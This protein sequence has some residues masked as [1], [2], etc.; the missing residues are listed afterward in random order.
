MKGLK[1]KPLILLFTLMW[2]MSFANTVAAQ[3]PS[4]TLLVEN[5]NLRQGEEQTV[6]LSV[7]NIPQV[8]GADIELT[9]DPQVLEVVD[10]DASKDGIQLQSGDFINPEQE[11]GFFLQNQVDN[12]NGVIDYALTLLN[13]A[14]AVEGDGVLANITLRA[15]SDGESQLR[16]K[17]GE[18]G[19]R[20]GEVI[21]VILE[22][23]PVPYVP[24]PRVCE[25][26][27]ISQL[28]C[29]FNIDRE[30][31]FIG[32]G[33]IVVFILLFLIQSVRL[34]LLRQNMS[35]KSHLA[36]NGWRGSGS[37]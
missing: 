19:T 3:D 1:K 24:K 34:A 25:E 15:K 33:V 32:A 36:N 6:Q 10:A 14:P 12:E 16:I 21:P 2:L 30:W 20:E 26:Q 23:K 5:L 11:P 29:E 7:E 18:F 35:A 22:Y 27:G 17:T 13:P 9:F 31:L 8:Y 37:G 28:L 4:P